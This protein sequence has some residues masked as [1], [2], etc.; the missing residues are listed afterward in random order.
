[1]LGRLAIG[2]LMALLLPAA[3]E[4]L[5]TLRTGSLPTLASGEPLIGL[6]VDEG[7]LLAFSAGAAWQL[8]D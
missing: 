6:A 5:S 4:P 3:A 7:K 8:G 1:M 2:W